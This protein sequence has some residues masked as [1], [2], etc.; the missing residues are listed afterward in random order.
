[1]VQGLTSTMIGGCRA[2]GSA[3]VVS[4]KIEETS[5]WVVANLLESGGV[6]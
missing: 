6:E 3:C 5:N 2:G 4:L 1:M